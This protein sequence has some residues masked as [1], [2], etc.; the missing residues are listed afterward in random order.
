MLYFLLQPSGRRSNGSRASSANLRDRDKRRGQTQVH[1]LGP[2][3]VE[4]LRKIEED[5]MP[6]VEEV[7]MNGWMDDLQVYVLFNSISVI[8]GGSLDD[9]ENLCEW[10]TV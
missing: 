6:K 2:T 5:S 3:P 8:S 1:G 4:P 9:N 7:S 10:N